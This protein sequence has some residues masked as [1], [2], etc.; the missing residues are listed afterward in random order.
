MKL[1]I[2]NFVLREK[3]QK[4]NMEGKTEKQIL[5]KTRGVSH[6]GLPI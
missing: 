3:I 1:K 6:S 5:I 4:K 2:D